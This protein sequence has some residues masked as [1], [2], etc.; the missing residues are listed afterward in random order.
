M[1]G[2]P[3][4]LGLGHRPAGGA[5]IAGEAHGHDPLVH[6]VGPDLGLGAL[7][8]LLDLLEERVDQPGP[9]DMVERVAAGVAAS[10]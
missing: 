10:T 8:E 7:D 3:R 9:A 1:A 2:P 4:R 5:L 6:H